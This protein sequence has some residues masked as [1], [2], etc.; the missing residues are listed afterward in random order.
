M[1]SNYGLLARYRLYDREGHP[2]LLVIPGKELVNVIGYGLYYKRYDGIYSEKK[3]KH[4]KHKSE[5]YT[6]EELEQFNA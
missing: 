6:A 3:F 5:L 1:R 4:I 2:A